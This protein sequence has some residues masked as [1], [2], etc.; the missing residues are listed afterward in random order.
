MYNYLESM[1]EDILD[2]IRDNYT[3]ADREEGFD[4][5]Y[6]TLTD[7]LWAE[8]S[9]TGNGTGK[10]FETEEEARDAAFSNTPLLIEAISEFGDNPND[11]K[12]ALLEPHYADVTIRCGLLGTA[13]YK[14]LKEWGV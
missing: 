3:E 11:Y 8:D 12:R 7:E 2:Y 10:Y 14:A 5:L 13:L 4:A 1:T 9:V 6:E